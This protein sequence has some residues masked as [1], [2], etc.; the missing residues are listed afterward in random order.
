M[1]VTEVSLVVPSRANFHHKMPLFSRALRR[2]R[3][4]HLTFKS[5]VVDLKCLALNRRSFAVH[6][7]YS[8][9][10]FYSFA[11]DLKNIALYY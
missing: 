3:F 5:S 10:D 2:M 1:T 11:V 9:L 7:K 4:H 6:L 8:A